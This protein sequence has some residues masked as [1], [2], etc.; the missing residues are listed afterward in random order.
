[1]A[2]EIY[3]RKPTEIMTVRWTGDNL[4]E[5]IDF[6]GL[7]PSA[8]HMTWNEYALLVAREGLMLF[9]REGKMK[10]SVGDWIILD[11]AGYPYACKPDHFEANYE[12]VE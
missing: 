5:V 7:H 6:T 8:Q 11:V 3:R 2:T 12:R 1:M 10:A 9:T 4:R